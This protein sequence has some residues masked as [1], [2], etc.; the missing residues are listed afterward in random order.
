MID[1]TTFLL[2][3]LVVA[4][5]GVLVGAGMVALVSRGRQLDEREQATQAYRDLAALAWRLV[6]PDQR[7]ALRSSAARIWAHWQP[8]GTPGM[9]PVM[10]DRAPAYVHRLID[11]WSG[12]PLDFGGCWVP[13]D[14]QGRIRA[15]LTGATP[16]VARDG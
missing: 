16:P 7:E 9:D 2:G 8:D 5:A 11:A 4:L 13:P 10:P 15:V 14:V 6:P 1:L 3:L 12:G